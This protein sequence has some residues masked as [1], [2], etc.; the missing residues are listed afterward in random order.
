M[1]WTLIY[2]MSCS[3]YGWHN[4]FI[5]KFYACTGIHCLLALLK[6]AKS[7]AILFAESADPV[8]KTSRSVIPRR[9]NRSITSLTCMSGRIV[10]C[11]G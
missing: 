1:I 9:F 8:A 2:T 7:D 5:P 3:R 10:L 6:L 4:L 11:S